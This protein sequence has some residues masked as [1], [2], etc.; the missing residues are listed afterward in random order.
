MLVSVLVGPDHE[1]AY[2][3][4]AIEKLFGGQRLGIPLREAFPG[5]NVS[6]LAFFD[7]VLHTGRTVEVPVRRVAIRDLS[8]GDVV[9]G[10]C[11]RR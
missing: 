8:G 7:E 6:A 1:L 2:V 4:A 11:S 10:T 5:M 9:C 3:N